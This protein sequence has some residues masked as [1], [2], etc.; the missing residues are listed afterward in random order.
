MKPNNAIQIHEATPELNQNLCP[1][2]RISPL[3]QALFNSFNRGIEF[4]I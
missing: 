2:Y 4:C 1:C 3:S